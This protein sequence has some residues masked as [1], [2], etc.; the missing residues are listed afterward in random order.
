M[1]LL[2]N[3]EKIMNFNNDVITLTNLRVNLTDIK[4]GQTYSNN[5]FLENISSVETKF[6]S[7]PLL[8]IFSLISIIVSILLK[9]DFLLFGII[10]SVVLLFAWLVTRKFVL[11]VSSNGGSSIAFQVHNID[12]EEIANFIYEIFLAKQKRINQIHKL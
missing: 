6:T 8:I 3:E 11:L 1:K 5:I 12:D 2:P 4:W 7:S 10:L 9:E